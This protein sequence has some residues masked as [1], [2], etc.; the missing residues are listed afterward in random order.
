[1]SDGSC[2][3]TRNV[4]AEM[5]P[6]VLITSLYRVSEGHD[7]STFRNRFAF[8]CVNH[9]SLIRS[10]WTSSKNKDFHRRSRTNTAF[11]VGHIATLNFP[12]PRMLEACGSDGVWD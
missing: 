9:L 2:G 8:D 4:I 5:L 11:A 6:A 12:K 10:A 7:E 3:L 1:M